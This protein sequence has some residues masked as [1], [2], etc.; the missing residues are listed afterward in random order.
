MSNTNETSA[1]VP[2][3]AEPTEAPETT[4]A[5]AAAEGAVRVVDPRLLV[6]E[7]G[8]K[9][10]WTEF[11]RKVRSGEIGSLPVVVGLIIIGIV[12]QAETG[13]FLTSYNLDQITLYAAGPGIMA[14][15]IVFVLLLG[16]IDLAVGSVAGLA[17]AVWAVLGSDMPDGLAILLGILSGTVIGAFHG[18]VFAKIGVPAFVVTLAGFL[19]WAGMQT[20]VMGEKST[21]TT[22]LGS[23]VRDLTSYYFEDVAAAYGLAIVV[24]VAFYLTQLRDARRRKA[25]EL[26]A[27]PQSEIILRTA[28]LAVLAL[29]AA[30]AFNQEQGLPLSLVIFLAILVITDF[31][32]RR[33]TYGRQVFA[34]GGGVEAARRAGINVSWIRI[35]V[36]M[37]SGT[38]GAVG[39]L[40]L[41]SATGG[42]DRS[43]GGGNQLMMCIAAAVI[44]G[45]SL[46][47][48]RGKVWSALLGILVIQ[49]IVQGLNQMNLSSNAIQYMITGA[50]LLIAVIIDSVSRKT[51]KTAGRA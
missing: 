13:N 36:F 43:L 22:P 18:I 42:A 32:L 45:T 34:V 12:F 40:F 38:L 19:G 21:I 6:R 50:V 25:A 23:F 39:G 5:P 28:L 33:T 3:Q 20:W 51:Q 30:Y 47:G 37:I 46:F 8:F 7:Q 15:G 31:V 14:V 2:A 4:E 48:G 27:R 49:S 24:I 11:K 44:G 1:K 9:G 17:G 26:P 41:A 35:S 29:L 16:E 10:Y